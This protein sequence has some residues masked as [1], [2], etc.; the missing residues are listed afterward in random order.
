[1]SKGLK[2][3][4]WVGAVQAL[5]NGKGGGKDMS[6]QATGTNVACLQQAMAIVTKHAEQKLGVTVAKQ[7]DNK[8]SGCH[9]DRGASSSSAVDL[10]KLNTHLASASYIVGFSPS[11]SD[12]CILNAVG[13]AATVN[14]DQLPHV[15]RW[16]KH[17]QSFAANDRKAFPG[18]ATS[19]EK[20]G[21]TGAQNSGGGDD[22]DDD[23]DD[24]F[25]LFGGENEEEKRLREVN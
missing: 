12:V 18:A 25:D 24:D 20:L 13:D 23:S 19:V 5:M 16:L 6:A 4:E 21:F 17:I 14:I 10:Q 1:M 2:A 9:G 22:D 11:Q 15:H 3:N 8:S 7:Q